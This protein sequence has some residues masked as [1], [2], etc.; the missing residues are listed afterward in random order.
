M[1]NRHKHEADPSAL[2]RFQ[3]SGGRTHLNAFE[4]FARKA[5]ILAG[6]PAAFFAALAVVVTWLATG[7]VFGFSDTWQLVINTSTT[8]VTFLMVFLLQHSQNRDTMA[9]QVK[10]ADLI[11]A[12]R[13]ANNELAT[14]EDLS[15]RELAELHRH[16]ARK[17]EQTLQRL[18]ARHRAETDQA[19]A[20]DHRAHPRAS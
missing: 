17:A 10:L 7:P 6:K 14:A 16:Y 11:I 4:R 1:N 13:G 9:L 20:L 15:E 3:L 12:V 18:Q 5:S 2:D 8:I 19:P